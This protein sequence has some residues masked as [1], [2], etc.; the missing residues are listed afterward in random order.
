[1]S[2]LR[3][4]CRRDYSSINWLLSRLRLMSSLPSYFTLTKYLSFTGFKVR[5]MVCLL[6]VWG[7]GRCLIAE[8]TIARSS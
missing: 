5:S 2:Y 3:A 1:M 7:V 6:M 8:M 4:L